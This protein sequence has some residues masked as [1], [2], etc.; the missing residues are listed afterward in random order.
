[1]SEEDPFSQW[2]GG[3]PCSQWTRGSPGLRPA[4]A[5]E[6]SR[7]PIARPGIGTPYPARAAF[8]PASAA[9]ILAP[10]QASGRRRDEG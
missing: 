5:H 7:W 1:M 4:L 8:R 2:R 3:G 9:R 6:R 10:R